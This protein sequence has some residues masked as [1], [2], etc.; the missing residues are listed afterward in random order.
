MTRKMGKKV[1]VIACLGDSPNDYTLR[2]VAVVEQSK[3]VPKIIKSLKKLGR[4]VMWDAEVR[5]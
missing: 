1:K 2:L 5:E 4:P 3:D